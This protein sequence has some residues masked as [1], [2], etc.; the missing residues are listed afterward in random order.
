MQNFHASRQ[1][2]RDRRA[3]TPFHVAGTNGDIHTHV[4][5]S[6]S[7]LRIPYRSKKLSQRPMYHLR[8]FLQQA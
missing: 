1:V 7:V 5:F 4:H 3:G 6:P 8:V 2:I